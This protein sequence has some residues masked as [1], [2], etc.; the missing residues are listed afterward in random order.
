MKE[1]DLNGE[2]GNIEIRKTFSNM[3]Q[4]ELPEMTQEE[5]IKNYREDDTIKISKKSGSDD[6]NIE[7]SEHLKRIKKELLASLERVKQLAKK[8]YGE[9]KT[10]AKT[11][12]QLEQGKGKQKAKQKKVETKEDEISKKVEGRERE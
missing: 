5:E 1:K 8:I 12:A 2:K 7:E 3:I 4:E 11:K 6:D 9:D 10:K